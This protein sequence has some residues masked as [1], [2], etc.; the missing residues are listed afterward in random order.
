MSSRRSGIAAC[1][2]DTGPL[3]VGAQGNR[4]VDRIIGLG[5]RL[6]WERGSAKEREEALRSNRAM[7]HQELWTPWV[8]SG[9]QAEILNRSLLEMAGMHEAIPPGVLARQRSSILYPP[10]IPN[11]IGIKDIHYL[12][13]S[14]LIRHRSIGD[15]MR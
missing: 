1:S 11:L 7:W 2:P 3:L 12:D 15:L 8:R 13:R 5:M 14:G 9:P 10:A 4:P 6:A